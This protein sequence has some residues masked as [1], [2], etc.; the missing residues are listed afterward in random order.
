MI[1]PLRCIVARQCFAAATGGARPVPALGR[2]VP[3]LARLAP[4]WC[5]PGCAACNFDMNKHNMYDY[6]EICGWM[7]DDEK[8]WRAWK[9]GL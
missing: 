4:A 7:V 5:C 6:L 2:L 9:D 3:S 1:A 8:E